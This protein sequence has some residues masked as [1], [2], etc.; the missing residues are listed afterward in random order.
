MIPATNAEP[1]AAS[2][3]GA[4]DGVR[5]GVQHLI[6]LVEDGSLHDLGALGLVGFL[7][8]LEQVRNQLPTVDRAVIQHGIE[9][10]VP[11]L[12]CERSMAR[13]LVSGLRL[14]AAEA[15]R[16]VRAAEHL[17]E[18][19]SLTGEPLEPYR[20]HL[21]Q[22]QRS[23]AITPEQVH[24]IDTALRSVDGRGFDPTDIEAGEKILT[25]AAESVG[26]A[27]L[28]VLATKV[29]DGIDP[30]GTLVDEKQHRDRRFLHLRKRPDGSWQGEFR[31]TP[32]AGQKFATLLDSLGRHNTTHC[33]INNQNGGGQTGSNDQTSGDG[34]Q[35]D[36]A[37]VEKDGEGGEGNGAGGQQAKPVVLPDERTRGQRFHD[38][39]EAMLDRLLRSDQ[40]PE[41]GGTPS[42]VIVHIDYRDLYDGTG[43]GWFSDGSPVSA[44]T[45]AEMAGEADI[46]W[47]VKNAKGA[48]LDLYRDRRIAS[49][50]QTLAL[51]ARDGGCSFPG[52]DVA[53]EW[54]E[55]HHVISWLNGGD[56]N[57]SN[58][59]L[60]CKYHHH[61]FEQRRWACRINNDGLPVW[62][63]P[64]WIDREQKPIL[65]PRITITNWRRQQPLDL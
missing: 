4:L 46:A 19:H 22:A 53:P 36:G 9:Q 33:P 24:V 23:G 32:D 28:R 30:D 49:P 50:A 40:L 17:A 58:L 61:Y 29:V 7:Q 52:C 54:C 15:G 2:L 12:L 25:E 18:R 62:I 1:A 51:Y 35:V 31:L 5:T 10:G 64:T 13:V 34:G 3:L 56:T 43:S 63:P 38:A 8:E 65:H 11:G 57:I 21:A 45:V 20:P 59:T 26:P 44:R 27:E 16:R 60:V 6:K 47:C 42:T 41:T 39:L 48:V 55:R 37:Q 14:S